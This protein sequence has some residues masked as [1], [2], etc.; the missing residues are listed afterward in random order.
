MIPVL[1]RVLKENKGFIIILAFMVLA[2]SSFLISNLQ[3]DTRNS[4]NTTPLVA[5]G[6]PQVVVP[7]EEE[8]EIANSEEQDIVQA[9]NMDQLLLDAAA[10][11]A[12]AVVAF[13]FE[14]NYEIGPQDRLAILRPMVSSDLLGRF[15]SFYA[16]EDWN[17]VFDKKLQIF[18]EILDVVVS[19]K[20]GASDVVIIVT[21]EYLDSARNPV[22]STLPT[23]FEVVLER[24]YDFE[25]WQAIDINFE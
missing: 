3:S 18:P 25:N 6:A 8:R 1:I 24:T 11:A 5:P 13:G 10:D 20:I 23:T 12:M 9:D 16:K 17:E 14:V 2:A 4:N 15:S 7:T 19:P 21:V 22:K